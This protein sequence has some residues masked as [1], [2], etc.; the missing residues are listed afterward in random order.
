MSRLNSVKAT[1]RTSWARLE[2]CCWGLR[3]RGRRRHVS[4]YVLCSEPT[5]ERERRERGGGRDGGSLRSDSN[6]ITETV[7]IH[8]TE[9][10]PL[11]ISLTSER[12][13]AALKSGSRS[14][15][16]QESAG[17]GDD[18]RTDLYIHMCRVCTLKRLSSAKLPGETIGYL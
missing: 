13:E 3:M 11:R 18:S 5:G 12:G 6:P 14:N 9:G 2:T 4:R 16:L 8:R 17:S 1:V 7:V 10:F 15:E